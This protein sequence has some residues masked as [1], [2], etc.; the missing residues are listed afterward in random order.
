MGDGERKKPSS[1]RTR[2][3]RT[4]RTY[5][6]KSG[7]TGMIIA[8]VFMVLFLIGLYVALG[9]DSGTPPRRDTGHSSGTS[10]PE[11]VP[12]TAAPRPAAARVPKNAF[13]VVFYASQK[14]KRQKDPDGALR[15]LREGLTKFGDSPDIYSEMAMAVDAKMAKAGKGSAAYRQ[16][17]GEK[18]RHLEKA[19]EVINGGKGW[20]QDAM[21]NKTTQLQTRIEQARKAASK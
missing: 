14:R 11:V 19:M 3:D 20:E 15:M 13:E 6:R 9:T 21:G 12:V 8:I 7:P 5:G 1:L 4:R 17:A 16:L 18:L 10:S 2:V